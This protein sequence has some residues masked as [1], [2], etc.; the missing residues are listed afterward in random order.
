MRQ[1]PASYVL[2]GFASILSGLDLCHGQ[3]VPYF[4]PANGHHYIRFDSPLDWF[5]AQAAATASTLGGVNGHLA[6]LTSQQENDLI[7]GAFPGGGHWLGG[8]QPAGG[9]EPAGGWEWVTGEPWEYT[10]WGQIEP[11]NSSGTEDG[12]NS[13]GNGQWNDLTRTV[14]TPYLVEYPTTGALF[15]WA[16]SAGGD[17]A[18]PANWSSDYLPAATDPAVFD[19]GSTGYVVTAAQNRSFSQ[20]HVGTDNVTLDLGAN[21]VDVTSTQGQALRVADG[22]GDNGVLRIT[23]GTVKTHGLGIAATGSASGTTGSL[24]VNGSTARLEIL[25]SEDDENQIGGGGDD[26]GSM[27]A[28]NGAAIIAPTIDLS[29]GRNG[30]TGRLHLDGAGTQLELFRLFVGLLGHGEVKIENQASAVVQRFVSIANQDSTPTGSAVVKTGGRLIVNGRLAV[31]RNGDGTLLVEDGG[32]V[33][34]ARVPSV[35]D[36][37][38]NELSGS[39]GEDSGPGMAIVRGESSTWINKDTLAI[40]YGG[41][42]KLQIESEGV[43]TANDGWLA[44]LETAVGAVEVTGAGSRWNVAENLTIGGTELAQGGQGVLEVKSGGRVDVGTTL[45]VWKSGVVDVSN[46]GSINVGEVV[47]PASAGSIELGGGAT[48]LGDGI[49]KGNV[50]V[51][52]NGFI[53]AGATVAPGNG[54][55]T[56]GRLTIDGDYTQYVR[57][58]LEIDLAGPLAGAQHDQLFVTG[59]ATLSNSSLHV[60]LAGGFTPVLGDSFKILDW[61]SRTGTYSSFA[62]PSLPS[63]HRWDTSQVNTSGILAVGAASQVLA[64]WTF[65]PG[66]PGNPPSA[67]GTTLSGVSPATGSGVAS[68]MHVSSGTT[69]DNPAGNGSQESMSSNN[70]AVGDFYQYRVNTVGLEKIALEFQQISSSSGPRDFQLQYSTDGSSFVDFGAPYAVRA[71]ANPAWNTLSPSGLDSFSFDLSAISSVNNQANLYLRLVVDSDQSSIGA[72]STGG[73]SRLDNVTISGSRIAG[74]AGDFN[75]DGA[76]DGTDFLVWQRQLGSTVVAYSGADGDGNGMI[77]AADLTIWRNRI[78]NSLVASQ[79]VSS[80]VPEPSAVGLVPLSL[81]GI[82]ACTRRRMFLL[83]S[84]QEGEEAIDVLS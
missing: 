7:T 53:P 74:L 25:G 77:N 10:S 65:E 49:V 36:P 84:G 70:W 27:T 37:N 67:L 30:G 15:R 51:A 58:R 20:L 5:A 35:V 1:L 45:R 50:V 60:S 55:V 12:L 43:V 3:S 62:L 8:F 34:S 13:H 68:G 59:H 61:G 46:Q 83:A 48:L 16:N 76:V 41:Q 56:T 71:N 29:L 75:D 80:V 73:T 26:I 82:I 22:A 72:I 28:L 31:G 6:T 17:V 44:A 14:A 18:T 33:E 79:V 66:T 64:R 40:G 32:I 9:A 57:G 4:N 23:S 42:G 39:V 52:G 63:G 38:L 81:A 69:W 2:L 47:G 21:T 78:G 54:G 19:L 24:E 11:N